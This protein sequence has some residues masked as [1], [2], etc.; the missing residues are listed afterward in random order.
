MVLHT[1]NSRDSSIANLSICIA[2]IYICYLSY[3]I[4]QEKMC[5]FLCPGT[6][7]ECVYMCVHRMCIRILSVCA[8]HYDSFTYRSP[9]G[10]KFTATLFMLF[11]QCVT[12]A[13]VAYAGTNKRLPLSCS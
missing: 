4:F 2:G 12:N 6:R 9:T 1:G 5:V 10:D 13:A 8:F 3:G 7:T 11:V